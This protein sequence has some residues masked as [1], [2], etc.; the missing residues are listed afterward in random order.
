MVYYRINETNQILSQEEME[1]N[2]SQFPWE[3]RDE[4]ADCAIEWIQQGINEGKV[5]VI[6]HPMWCVKA[7]NKAENE[8]PKYYLFDTGLKATLGKK[9]LALERMEK[10]ED[11]Y[12]HTYWPDSRESMCGEVESFD[13]ETARNQ[14]VFNNDVVL[15]ETYSCIV[16]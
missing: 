6:G 14:W 4:Y 12:F 3:I 9:H 10:D 16:A 1:Q 11:D 13:D 5:S 15:V 7:Y 8:A 2:F